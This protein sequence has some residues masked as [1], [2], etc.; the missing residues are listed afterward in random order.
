M[1][2]KL[3]SQI[4]LQDVKMAICDG[5]E[6]KAAVVAGVDDAQKAILERLLGVDNRRQVLPIL[7]RSCQCVIGV[8]RFRGSISHSL[9]SQALCRRNL[10]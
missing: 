10:L 1:G 4:I 3:E 2:P 9:A 5:P 6:H 7:Q 8:W